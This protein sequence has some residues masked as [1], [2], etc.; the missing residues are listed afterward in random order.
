MFIFWVKTLKIDYY[1][2]LLCGFSCVA[3]NL[4]PVGLIG[5]W[6][7]ESCRAGKNLKSET[8]RPNSISTI[9]YYSVF[10]EKL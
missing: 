10:H 3:L 1:M 4:E 5:L 9:K 8:E 2:E 7:I 6:I